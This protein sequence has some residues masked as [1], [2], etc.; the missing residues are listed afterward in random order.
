MIV[1]TIAHDRAV[2]LFPRTRAVA[3]QIPLLV[4][5]VLFTVSGLLLLFSA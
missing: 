3:G 1:A 2:G 5:M 4:L